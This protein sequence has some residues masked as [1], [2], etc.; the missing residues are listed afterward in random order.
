MIGA[1]A[2][3]VTL[4]AITGEKTTSEL[5]RYL[6]RLKD[7]VFCSDQY[8]LGHN[9]RVLDSLLR[10]IIGSSSKKMCDLKEPRYVF[11]ECL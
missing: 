4:F 5:K 6:Y 1:N 2:I 3:E 8:S 10:D 9:S 11:K 7:E